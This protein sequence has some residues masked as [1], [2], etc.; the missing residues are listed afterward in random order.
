MIQRIQDANTYVLAR[1]AAMELFDASK[2]WPREE[3]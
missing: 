2:R 1:R 3:R